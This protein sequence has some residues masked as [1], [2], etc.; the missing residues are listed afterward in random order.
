MDVF[1]VH[2]SFELINVAILIIRLFIGVCFVVHGLGKL[3][4]VGPGNMK[5]FTEWLRALK[6]PFPEFQAKMAMSAELVGGGLIATGFLMR[7]ACAIL[8]FTML[9]AAAI[10]HKGGGYLI[11]N[12]P[13]GNEYTINLAAIL[14]ALLLLGPGIYSIDAFVFA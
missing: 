14:G 2:T 13:P 6:V 1:L 10:G 3:G 11:T 9:I 8:I 5:G 12:D 4:Y 7:P